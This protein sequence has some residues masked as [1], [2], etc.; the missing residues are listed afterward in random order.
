MNERQR[1]DRRWPPG[2]MDPFEAM[3]HPVRRYLVELF[4][5]YEAPVGELADMVCS[6]YGIG[7]PAVTR[8]LKILHRAGFVRVRDAWPNRYYRLDDTAISRLEDRVAEL[9]RLWD[10]RRGSGYF[11]RAEREE[12]RWPKPR[13]PERRAGSNE[14]GRM[15]P[16]LQQ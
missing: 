13:S 12:A 1:F 14:I 15:G 7:W 10:D 16:G 5:V 9:R 6:G 4:A 2:A 11:S 3:A 8:H